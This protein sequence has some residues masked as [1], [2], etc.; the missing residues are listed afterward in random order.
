LEEECN[1][2]ETPECG[3]NEFFD[4]CPTI[5]DDEIRCDALK[6]NIE[7]TFYPEEE[8][9]CQAMCTCRDG[10]VRNSRGKCEK[11][12]KCCS[13]P[14]E[15]YVTCP[16]P[17]PGGTCQNREF[18]QCEDH[19]EKLGCQCRNGFVRENHRKYAKCVPVLWCDE[20]DDERLFFEWKIFESNQSR[21]D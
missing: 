18:S 13:D 1:A 3:Q 6:R 20:N 10:F 21:N 14:N 19:C 8:T 4:I 11:L 16:N 12:E 17:C 5:W 15:E 2:Y 7:V 9:F